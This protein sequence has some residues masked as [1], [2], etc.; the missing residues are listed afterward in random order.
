GM[1]LGSGTVQAGEPRRPGEPGRT[2]FVSGPVYLPV[3]SP[4][5]AALPNLPQLVNDLY[6]RPQYLGQFWVG[7]VAWPAL[8]QYFTYDPKQDAGP[9]L[10]QFERTPSEESLNAVHT[11]GDKVLDLGWV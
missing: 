9:L 10:G 4:K 1:Y 5:N 7:L 3:S 8:W 6:N 2:Y 11:Y